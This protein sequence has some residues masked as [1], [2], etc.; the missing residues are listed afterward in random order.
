MDDETTVFS[1]MVK[2]LEPFA[3]Y[4]FRLLVSNSHGETSSPWVSFFTAQDS[5]FHNWHTHLH[6]VYKH[7]RKSLSTQIVSCV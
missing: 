3:E 7:N 2:Y 6:N 1:H 4:H 5:E